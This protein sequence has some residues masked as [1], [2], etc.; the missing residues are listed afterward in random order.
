MKAILRFPIL[1]LLISMISLLSCDKYDYNELA[2]TIWKA[3]IDMDRYVLPVQINKEE[4]HYYVLNFRKSEF[5]LDIADSNGVI[6]R[7]VGDGTYTL[8]D[9]QITVNSNIGSTPVYYKNKHYIFY[10]GLNF[11]RQN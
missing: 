10:Y 7:N 3:K 8:E 11:Y 4:Q 5:T 1:C 9:S 6:V 2:G